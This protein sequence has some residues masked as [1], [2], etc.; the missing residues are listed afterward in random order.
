M[1]R[2]YWKCACWTNS[3]YVFKNVCVQLL[4]HIWPFATPWTI[5][6]QAPL[7]M[8][9]SREEYWS[10]LPF[11]SPGALPDPGIEQHLLCL[12][13]WQADS[14]L[15]APPGK[16]VFKDKLTFN[17][18]PL[19]VNLESQPKTKRGITVL[20][21]PGCYYRIPQTGWLINNRNLLLTAL[22]VPAWLPSGEGHLP[23]SLLLLYI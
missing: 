7:S 1:T 2:G 13:H 10:G 18:F 9:F 20:V 14:L 8:E 5:A 12:L 15:L 21:F 22:Q 23:G 3:T 4:S 17:S 16:P 6:C 19:N 11:P